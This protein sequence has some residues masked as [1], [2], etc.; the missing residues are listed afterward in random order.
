MI[1][2][3]A[4]NIFLLF[5]LATSINAYGMQKNSSPDVYIKGAVGCAT[6]ANRVNNKGIDAYEFSTKPRPSGIYGIGVGIQQTK[7]IRLEA[8]LAMLEYFKQ[9]KLGV[10]K[11]L[12]SANKNPI[13]IPGFLILEEYKI[14]SKLFMVSTKYDLDHLTF[15]GFTPYLAANLGLTHNKTSQYSARPINLVHPQ[16][17]SSN[18]ATKTSL[19]YGIGAGTRYKIDNKTL[20]EIEYNFYDLGKFR[21]KGLYIYQD[22]TPLTSDPSHIMRSAIKTH[23]VSIA[24]VR[25]F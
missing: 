20:I 7:N 14:R 8:N 1:S 12:T 24:I 21:N 2:A 10:G 9:T 23:A 22:N 3:T 6:F 19:I 17:D 11:F 15:K 25:Y 5:F 16:S 13:S 4:R 18:S